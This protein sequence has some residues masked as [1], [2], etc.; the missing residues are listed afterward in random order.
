MRVVI[1]KL[2]FI[3]LSYDQSDLTVTEFLDFN[4]CVVIS[5]AMVCLLS[6]IT[7]VRNPLV[8]IHLVIWLSNIE[9]KF[10]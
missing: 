10:V 5:H 7:C 4:K 6:Q 1:L 3:Q 8:H 2:F 9:N